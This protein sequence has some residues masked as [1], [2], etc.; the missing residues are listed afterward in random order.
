[1]KKR[2]Y[3]GA[4]AAFSAAHEI[5]DPRKCRLPQ[6]RAAS[7]TATR[8]TTSTRWPITICAC[9]LRPNFR[10]RRTIIAALSSCAGA[11]C[12]G[13]FEEFSVAVK[14]NV[15]D[16]NRYIALLQPRPGAD[17]CA[18]QYDAALA[19]FAEAQKLN[20]DGAADSGLSLHR[21]YTEMGKFDEALADCNEVLGEDSEGD[22]RADQ[23]RQRLSRPR[24]ISTRRSTITTRSSGSI[25]T[26]SAPMPAAGSSSRNAATSPP[27]APTTAPPAPRCAKFDDIETTWRA[28]VARERLAAL[29]A[30][31]APARC[32]QDLPSAPL[33]GSAQGGAD[34]RQR[35]LQERAAAGQSAARRQADRVDLSRARLCHR[36][37]GARSHPRQILRSAARIRR[38][39][40]KADWAVVYYAGHGM[41][42]GGVNYLI[43]TDARL[44]ADQRRGEPGGGA[45]AGD[46]RRS[47]AR[48]SCGW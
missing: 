7:P 34:R 12:S 45:G 33:R 39:A 21:T 19:D 27:R 48:A 1:M 29:L 25:R 31:V 17:A 15:H 2:D 40:E 22:L 35:R 9:K 10:Q 24:A 20:P 47:P 36:D 13:R 41:E 30:R 3:D 46:R 43:P 5:A 23:P 26:I 14:L 44:A 18:R 4:I 8:A 28:A 16:Q 42:I 32:R 37:A 11:I 38:E 6:S